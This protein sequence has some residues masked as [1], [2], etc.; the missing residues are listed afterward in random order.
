[1]I[2]RATI[3]AEPAPRAAR[4]WTAA[5]WLMGLRYEEA[6]V[7]QLLEGVQNMRESTTNQATLREGREEGRITGE[8]RM[9][10]RLGTKRFGP[11]DAATV[12]AIEA[13]RDLDRLEALGERILDPDLRD[14]NDLLRTP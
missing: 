3:Q 14:W 7:A 2:P 12:T 1:V 9:L 6:L 13:I 11:P 8:Q 4:L 5:Y 10:L